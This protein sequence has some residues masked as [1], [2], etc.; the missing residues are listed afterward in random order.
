MLLHH[1]SIFCTLLFTAGRIVTLSQG[2]ENNLWDRV[3]CHHRRPRRKDVCTHSDR[4]GRK[5]SHRSITAHSCTNNT[6]MWE[7]VL[8][9]SWKLWACWEAQ[10]HLVNYFI[11]KWIFFPLLSTSFDSLNEWLDTQTAERESKTVVSQILFDKLATG[12]IFVC[13]GFMPCFWIQRIW[14]GL[15]MKIVLHA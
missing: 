1:I 9:G 12:G 3:Q 10:K 14:N 2:Q 7:L 4:Q 6:H 15:F 11:C 13:G 8:V 5:T